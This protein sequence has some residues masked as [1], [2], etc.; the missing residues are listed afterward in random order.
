MAICR[1]GVLV[2]RRLAV[3]ANFPAHPGQDK[4][5]I[6]NVRVMV[7]AGERTFAL[8]DVSKRCTPIGALFCGASVQQVLQCR[9]A[10]GLGD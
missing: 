10:I 1:V 6:G 2:L 9:Q 7:S 4:G 3:E 5:Q 8:R